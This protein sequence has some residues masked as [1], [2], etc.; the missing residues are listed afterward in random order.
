VS[1]TR[2]CQ[3]PRCSCASCTCAECTC[4]GA[5]IGELERRVIDVLW[6]EPGT[7]LSGRQVA[8]ALPDYAYTTVATVL[9]RLAG[10]GLVHRRRQGRT[11]RFA[12]TGTRATHTAALM[13][14]ALGATSDPD[15]ALARF[16]ETVSR[17]EAEALRRALDALERTP[18]KASG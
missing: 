11:I 18:K 14:E 7:D 5:R 13:H 3:N 16:A 17:S 4:G 6:E 12:A 9:D 1:T 2:T 15:A 10:K 8:N